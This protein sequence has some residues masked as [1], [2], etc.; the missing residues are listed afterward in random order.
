M[1]TFEVLVFRVN[2]L[3]NTAH[4]FSTVLEFIEEIHESLVRVLMTRVLLVLRK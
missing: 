2:G 3:G 4:L 1:A